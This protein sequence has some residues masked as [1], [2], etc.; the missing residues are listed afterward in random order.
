MKAILF[1]LLAASALLLNSCA[2]GSSY[3]DPQDGSM[4]D[5]SQEDHSNMKM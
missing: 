1:L 3:A 4:P 5:M 2:T